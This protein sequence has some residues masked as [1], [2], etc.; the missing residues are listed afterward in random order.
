MGIMTRRSLIRSSAGM[1]AA[2]ALARPFIANAAAK[3]AEVWWT[4]GFAE[5][6]DI[7]FKAM[8]AEYEKASGNHLDY[9]II[10]YAPARQ[11][12]VSAVTSGIVPDLFQNNPG[13]IIA[14]YAW[15]NK[16]VDVTDVVDTQREE[17]A[18]TAMM[19]ANCYNS[20]E[21][22]RSIYG[23]PYT[24][25][26]LPNHVWRH[27]V[28]KA[29]FKIEDIPKKTWNGYYDFFK[30]VQKALRAKG[31]RK[32]YGMGLTLSTTGNDTNNQFNYFLI[33]NGGGGIVTKDGKLNANDPKV[34]EAA[35]KALEYRTNA[36][37][38][39]FIPPSAISWNDSDNNNAFHSKQVVMDLDG[40]IS[41]EVAIIKN[42][43]DY[44]DIV[45]MGPP[46]G[47][48]GKPFPVQ[49][50]NTFGLIPKGAKN[51]E[52]AKDFLK[53]LIQ[54]KVLNEYLKT[55]LGRNVPPM[56]SIVKKDPWWHADPHRAAY[57]DMTVLGPTEP[58]FW[59]DN[60]AWAQVQNEH[61]WGVA[62][63]DIIGGGMTPQ[64]AVEKALKRSEEIFA[65]YPM[66]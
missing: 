20:V 61:L 1:V 25:S 27:L 14:I 10:P 59:V 47:N 16:L 13:E 40:T 63:N 37:K 22:K 54:P 28:E 35:I 44:D 41:T 2:S 4:Q 17:F 42:K 11:K 62:A 7:S 23:V 43:A 3:T 55:G 24:Q 5:E 18:E 57:T 32:I 58:I 52:V 38:E 33:A 29:G 45:T 64:A 56:P 19:T 34:R 12:I 30:E 51:V 31:E 21:K 53:Y 49:T 66:S 39:G 8:V 65:K 9:S 6:E 60:P 46:A 36:Y 48:D 50:N 15:D 26:A